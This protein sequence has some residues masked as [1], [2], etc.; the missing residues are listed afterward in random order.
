MVR[1]GGL[2]YVMDPAEGIGKRVSDMTLDNGEKVEASKKYKVAGW[3]TVASQAP[4]PA[5]WDVVADYLRAK[6]S[7]RVTKINEPKL[8]NVKGNPGIE[9]Y[10]GTILS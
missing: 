10:S 8:K 1:V 7:A 3:A 2:D 4:G 5:I 6:K 9:D